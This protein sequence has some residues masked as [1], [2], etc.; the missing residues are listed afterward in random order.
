MSSCGLLD[1]MCGFR[2][3][4]MT[5]LRLSVEGVDCR[6]PALCLFT[7]QIHLGRVLPRS[8]ASKLQ[9][10]RACMYAVLPKPSRNTLQ[11]VDRPL[12]RDVIVREV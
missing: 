3:D 6:P 8:N 10:I 2:V 12:S 9:H 5:A 4:P 11:D 1:A 7:L